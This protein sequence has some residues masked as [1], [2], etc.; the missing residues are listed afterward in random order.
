[1][2]LAA[3]KIVSRPGPAH[4]TTA[5][6]E[7]RGVAGFLSDLPFAILRRMSRA[8]IAHPWFWLMLIAFVATRL[9]DAHLHLCFDGQEAASAM[10]VADG[11]VHNDAHHTDSEHDDRDVDVFDVVLLKKVADSTDLLALTFVV[12][13]LVFLIPTRRHDW[14]HDLA[15]PVALR[16]IFRLRPPLRGPPV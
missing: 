9:A 3:P 14:P 2:L 7:M 5:C 6:D 8:R 13:W 10:H 4:D 12:A 16:S 11:A 15:A 1:M